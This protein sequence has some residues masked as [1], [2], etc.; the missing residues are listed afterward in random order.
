[1]NWGG[2]WNLVGKRTEVPIQTDMHTHHLRCGGR[3]GGGVKS[4]RPGNVTVYM[5]LKYF[6]SDQSNK[7]I[8]KILLYA[9]Q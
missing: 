2:G 9:F 6:N 5:N 7:R 1:M 3:G 4:P 8:I